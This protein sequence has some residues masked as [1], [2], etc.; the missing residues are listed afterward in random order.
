[1][2]YKCTNVRPPANCFSNLLEEMPPGLIVVDVP[3]RAFCF[4]SSPNCLGPFRLIFFNCQFNLSCNCQCIFGPIR[5]KISNLLFF[6]FY[7]AFTPGNML[8]TNVNMAGHTRSLSLLFP[9]KHTY[10]FRL[11]Q[12]EK[13][14]SINLP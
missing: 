7:I 6:V 10:S 8:I 3:L 4:A 1:M 13:N 9:L 2:A 14:V 5:L 11:I 12:P